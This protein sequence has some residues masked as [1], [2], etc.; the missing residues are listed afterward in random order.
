MLGLAGLLLVIPIAAL[1]AF[2]AGGPERS[3]LVLGPLVTFALPAVAMIAFWWDDWPG[4]TLRPKWWS[5]WFD[6]LVIAVIAVV[7]TVLGQIVV[8]SADLRGI[9]EPFPGPGH[10]PTFPAVM[11]LAGAAFAAMLQLTL[12]TEGWPLRLLP[13]IPAGL[14]ALGVSWLVAL[15]V[16]VG[17]IDYHPPA[18]SG[19]TARD[20]VI[21]GAEL[22]ALLTVIGVWQVWLYL[23][24]HGWPFASLQQRW[25]RLLSAN[26]VTIGGGLLTYLAITGISGVDPAEIT[27]GAGSLIAAGLIV[28]MLFEG[29]I[30]S[31]LTAVWDRVVSVTVIVILA[32]ALFASLSALA[33]TFTFTRATSAAWVAQATLNAISVSVILHVAIGRRWPF[34]DSATNPGAA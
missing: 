24:W 29:A 21:G 30:R 9:F 12:V 26:V 13:R 4:T 27:A 19:L 8:G 7:L 11:P 14:A 3:V 17:L 34:G 5:G 15:G 10:S 28:S 31:H 22:G 20:G 23:A 33:D 25:I 6:T 18:D 32:A 1:L 16:Y 2:G